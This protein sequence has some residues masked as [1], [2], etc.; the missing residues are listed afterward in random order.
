M[1]H[2]LLTFVLLV[3]V[4]ACGKSK[5]EPSVASF[6][7]LR[8]DV[9]PFDSSLGLPHD[10]LTFET[11]IR[12]V[13]FDAVQRDKVLAAAQL[14]KKV[15]GSE[16]FR[17]GVLN[18]T[19]NGVRA[20]ANNDGYS[21]EQIYRII[22]DGAEVL[23]NLQNNMLDVELELYYQNSITIGYTYPDSTRIWMNTKYFDTYTPYQVA[24]NLFH[25]W[26]HKLGFTHASSKTEERSSSVPYALGYLVERLARQMD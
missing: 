10:A 13:N 12:T 4:S 16:A 9:I 21:N 24:D 8:T 2:I 20:F 25:E 7:S 15:V 5:D 19:Y 14:I 26:C 1:P 23:N 18:Y 3:A 22:I 6:Q 17:Q 11:N